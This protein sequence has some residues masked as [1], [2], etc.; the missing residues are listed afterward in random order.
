MPRRTLALLILAITLACAADTGPGDQVVRYR[1]REDPP[2]IDPAFVTDQVSAAVVRRLH[3][4]LVDF[5]AKTLEVIPR[6]AERWDI[7]ED[8]L[9]YT[10]H[11]R[12]GVLFHNGR[13]VTA[14]DAAWSLQRLV[15]PATRSQREWILA[16]IQGAGAFHQGQAD[17]IAGISVLDDHT[18]QVTLEKPYAPFLGQLAMENTAILPRE[19]WAGSTE[20]PGTPERNIGCGPFRLVE[21]VHHNYLSVQAFDDYYDGR[22]ELD[23]IIFRFIGNLSTSL[24]EYRAG[25]I[26]ILDE[27]VSGQREV[28]RET[29][30]DEM[31]QWPQMAAYFFGFNHQAEPFKGNKALRQAINYAVDKEY[32]CRVLQEGKDIPQTGILP[33][34]V[35]GHNPDLVGYP[36]D[37][38]RARQLLVEAGYPGGEG[39][40]EIPLLYNTSENHQ[41]I[42]T[43]IQND[44]GE[45]GIKISL[46][47]LDWAAFLHAVEGN[48]KDHSETP[49]FRLGWFADYPDPD[50]F[51]YVL[52]HTDNWGPA[53]NNALYSNPEF[54]RLVDEARALTDMKDRIP[55][56]QEA[57]RIAVDDA[58]W[59]FLYFYQDE[60]LVKPYVRNFVLSPMG[61]H[62]APL[63]QITLD[64]H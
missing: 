48:T 45:V 50:N 59:L 30:G 18:L 43:Q 16:P 40:P 39:L 11:L 8:G 35:P 23:R 29:L 22:P 41:R 37:P 63:E 47:N 7:S 60:A 38:Q 1:L 49:F 52:L 21:W 61:D 20:D 9:T 28:L 14:Q 53:G 24:E 12:H 64:A 2:T 54:D 36:Y 15:D 57:E 27:I 58:A 46:R 56:Y 51:L 31:R 3:A 62:M 26:D 6:V 25:G 32:L 42:A 13:E 44:L 55:L 17:G 5:D 33:P 4:G 10:F 19:A 34:G